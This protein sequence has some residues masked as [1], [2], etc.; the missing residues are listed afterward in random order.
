MSRSF[1]IFSAD[2]ILATLAGRKTQFRRC[3][4]WKRIAKD[5]GC[6]KGRLAYSDTFN[7]WAVFDGNG[8]AH[9]SL[10]QAPHKV[11]DVIAVK[12][13]YHQHYMPENS[14]L[15]GRPCYRAD[16]KCP[17][18]GILGWRSPATMPR[19]ASRIRI[20]ITGVRVEQLADN[21]SVW[22]NTFRRLN[23]DL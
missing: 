11:G 18:G 6:T 17:H 22:V 15:G 9:I 19:W 16:G 2:G 3:V 1:V 8:P 20:E 12:E 23:D 21:P 13:A 4:D 14:P 5:S 7:S 10:I